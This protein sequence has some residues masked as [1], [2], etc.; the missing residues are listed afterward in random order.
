MLRNMLKPLRAPFLGI[1]LA[2]G[3]CGCASTMDSGLIKAQ[4]NLES[5]ELAA[6]ESRSC[7]TFDHSRHGRSLALR[8]SAAGEASGKCRDGA[9]NS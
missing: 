7:R 4:P 2:S 8:R 1:A 3:V 5:P 6:I 9:R